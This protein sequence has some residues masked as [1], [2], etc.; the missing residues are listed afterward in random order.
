MPCRPKYRANRQSA[1]THGTLCSLLPNVSTQMGCKRCGCGR[2]APAP[3]APRA[4]TATCAQRPT[5]ANLRN[6]LQWWC[7]FHTHVLHTRTT[8]HAHGN[9][10]ALFAC[11]IPKRSHPAPV[12]PRGVRHRASA[13]WRRLHAKGHAHSHNANRNSR[14][15]HS[16]DKARANR[17]SSVGHARAHGATHGHPDANADGNPHRAANRHPAAYGCAT[18]RLADG[19]LRAHRAHPRL[20]GLFG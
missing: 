8:E 9:E 15:R 5:C 18:Y 11:A 10:S 3:L 13:P 17:G 2:I 20:G 12:C 16:D 4:G 7:V 14:A 1:P 6:P 19:H